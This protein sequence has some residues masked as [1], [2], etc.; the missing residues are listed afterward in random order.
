MIEAGSAPQPSF[1]RSALDTVWNSR[2]TH[3]ESWDAVG[4]FVIRAASAALLFLTQI[5]F[6]RWMGASEYGIFVAAWTCVLVVGGLCGLGFS[7][8][9][10]RL[11][12]QYNAGG[13]YASFRGLLRG[14]RMVAV[15][16]ASTIAIVGLMVLWLRGDLS[17][18]SLAIP[19]LLALLCLPIFAFADVQDGLGRGQGWTIEAITPHYIVRP[20][21]LLLLIPIVSALGFPDNAVTG[22]AIALATLVFATS[23]QTVLLR[24]RIQAT[25]PEAPPAYH[26]AN[27]FKISLPL[28]AG[29]ICDLAVQNADILLLAAFRP[30]EETGIYYAAAKTAG[31]ALFIHYAVGT[32]YAGRIAAAHALN[33]QAA[34][35]ALTS[36]AVRWTFIPSATVTV[37][38]LILGYPVLAGFGEQFTDAYPLM[39][40]LAVGILAKSAT[41]PAD[42]IL[43]M[44]GHQ[45]ASAVS[46]GL[47]AV[48]SVTLNLILIPI[49]GVTGA[50]IATSSALVAA[51]VFN[52]LAARRLE[53]LNLFVLAN[54]PRSRPGA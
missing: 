6:A 40:I 27:W 37:A 8:M 36:K 42:T 50:A 52:W 24:R 23:L 15:L 4:V 47:A 49:W 19:M 34:V 53:G 46:I 41:G 12:P 13:D 17:G 51:S 31:L 3:A 33:D 44:L 54:L 43:N 30:S 29:S 45:R 25:I 35:K 38:I 16:S 2:T 11:A 28:L 18:A 10:M 20:L 22:M 1:M 26:F 7:T 9:M 48:L 39:F 32:A 21:A 14:G 5:A